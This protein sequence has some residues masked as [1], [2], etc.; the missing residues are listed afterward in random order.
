MSKRTKR[1]WKS[2]NRQFKS[3][4]FAMLYSDKKELLELYNAV[5]STQYTDPELLEVNTLENAIYVGMKNDL[6][7]LIASRLYLYEHQSTVNPNLP[8]RFLL[9][10]SDLYSNL[11]KDRN[12]YGSRKVQ[13][14][15]P[16]FLIFYNGEKEQPDVQMLKLSELFALPEDHP[17][18]ELEAVMLNINKGHNRKLMEACRSLRDYA[19]Y[20][21]RVRRYAKEMELQKAVER[22]VEECIEEGILTEFL[23]KNRAEVIHVSIYE[24][25]VEKHMRQ[26]KEESWEEGHRT[27]LEEGRR[28][29]LEKGREEILVKQIKKKLEKGL[30]PEEIADML[31]EE[32]ETI[33]DLIERMKRDNPG[34]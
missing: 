3:T 2:V 30:T 34:E 15:P 7:F 1:K 24:Y 10:I 12:L 21:D 20:T 6:S 18:L 22:A 23:R 9:Y 32:K 31:E 5:N 4:V 19:E 27:G 13:I 17:A 26:E 16:R 28:I 14:P 29:G 11:V 33:K 8:L 25:D